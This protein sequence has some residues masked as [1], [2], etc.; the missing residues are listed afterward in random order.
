MKKKSASPV[1]GTRILLGVTGCIAA[2]K[3][4]D[5]VSRLTQWGAEVRVVMTREA[6]EFVT[7]LALRALSRGPVFAEMFDSPR[8]FDPVHVSLAEWAE[9]LVVAPATANLIGKVACGIAD[10]L[11]TCSVMATRAPVLIAPA[12]NTA[13]YENKIVQENIR[14]LKK[15]GYRFVG[16][17]S[18]YLACGC[19]GI[20]RLASTDEIIAAIE[21]LV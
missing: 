1:N 8:E 2:Y 20:G 16:P 9:I 12:M 4:C 11:L 10:D 21:R 13:M 15:R 18:G 3:S 14:K 19:E 7:P 17:D 6:C 5:L